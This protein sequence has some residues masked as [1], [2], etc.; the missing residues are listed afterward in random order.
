MCQFYHYGWHHMIFTLPLHYLVI[1]CSST[2]TRVITEP[3]P[4]VD[5]H[6]QKS[7]VNREQ[8]LQK[9]TISNSLVATG[10]CTNPEIISVLLSVLVRHEW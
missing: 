3:D 5:I 10:T 4:T 7:L 2:P 9:Y 8:L 1:S 6:V